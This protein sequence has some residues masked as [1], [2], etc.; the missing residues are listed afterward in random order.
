MLAEGLLAWALVQDLFERD[1]ALRRRLPPAVELGEV[2]GIKAGFDLG[3]G[4]DFACGNFDIKK[5]YKEL[6]SKNVREE[7]LDGLKT[8]LQAELAS[9]PLVLACYASPTVCDA[10]KH[11]R[12]SASAMLGMELEGCRSLEQSVGGVE[13]E[14]KARAIQECMDEQSRMGATLDQAQEACKNASTF[15]G[16]DGRKTTQIDVKRDVGLEGSLVGDLRIGAGTLSASESGS[17]VAERYEERRKARLELW[18]AALADPARA[19][20]AGPVSRA[21]VERLAAMEPARRDAA[22]RSIAAAQALAD[23][24]QEVHEAERR[25]E[26]AELNA[27]PEVRVEL[28]RRRDQLRHEI[29]RIVERFEAERRIASA[30]AEA[31]GAASEELSRRAR[32][33]LA[34][35]RAG[36]IRKEEDERTRPWGCEVKREERR[37]P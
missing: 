23:L 17:A 22:V 33:R 8:S 20:A 11:Y 5:T 13:R 29:A 16:I 26:A 9:S 37:A 28:E 18:R 6:F 7:Y 36:E 24:V 14:T 25:L 4:I 2:T 15:R 31:Q 27:A 10:I 1:A 34:P 21:E 30:V 12:V 35:R 3:L 32:E 19:G